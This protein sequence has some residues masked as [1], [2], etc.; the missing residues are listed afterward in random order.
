MATKTSMFSAVTARSQHLPTLDRQHH[1]RYR[2]YQPPSPHHEVPSPDPTEPSGKLSSTSAASPTKASTDAMSWSSR[3]SRTSKTSDYSDDSTD[4]LSLSLSPEAEALKQQ[5]RR[6]WPR[7]LF[8]FSLRAMRR[9]VVSP[10]PIPSEFADP[11]ARVA[12][13]SGSHIP[14]TLQMHRRQKGLV[15]RR[16]PDTV[17]E[18]V[19]Y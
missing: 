12:T 9:V 4:M 5:L 17:H 7:P 1:R 2:Y 16:L 3:L 6:Q 11:R 15:R 18:Y 14:L 19:T 8:R 13:V 10:V